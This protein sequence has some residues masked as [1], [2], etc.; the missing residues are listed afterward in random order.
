[1]S[2][3]VFSGARTIFRVNDKKV[4]FASGC[5]G[6][7]EV[8][9]EAVDVLDKIEVAEYVQLR[10]FPHHLGDDSFR[11]HQLNQPEQARR[12]RGRVG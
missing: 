12:R 1:M 5:D 3:N 10:G 7:E 9:Y 11:T 2:T 6:N 8:L 4:A